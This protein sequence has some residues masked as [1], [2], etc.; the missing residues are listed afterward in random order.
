MSKKTKI[1]LK[2]E[3][4]KLMFSNVIALIVQLLKTK[5]LYLIL[6][7]GTGKTTDIYA[8][9]MMDIAYDMPGCYYA[10]VSDTY[11]NAIKNVVPSILEGWERNGY[12]EDIHYVVGKR[13]PD[14]FKKP[15]KPPQSWKHTIT[16]CTG[17]H[18]KLVSMDRPST[19]AG[20]SYQ[21]IGGDEAKYLSEQK[22]NKLTPAIRG[23][24]VRFG[25]SVYYRGRTFMTDMPNINH[26]EHDWILRMKKNMNPEQIELIL[27]T[28][29]TLNDIRKQLFIYEDLL[30]KSTTAG[31]NYKYQLQVKKIQKKLTRWE[32]RYETIRK[33]STF[34]YE[35]SSY[36]N[37]DILTEGFFKDLMD[38]MLFGEFKTSVLTISPTLEKG[39]RF[40]GNLSETNFYSDSYT[41]GN[42]DKQALTRKGIETTSLDLKYVIHN[43]PIEVGLD[44]GN[45]CSLPTAQLQPDNKYRVLK[46]FFTLSPEFLPELG[47][48]FREFYKFHKDKTVHLWHDRAANA[49]KDVGEDHASKIKKAIEETK[50]G[51]PSGWSCT[52]M[53]RGQGNITHQQEYELLSAMCLGLYGLP[54]LMIDKNECKELKSSMENTRLIIR[55]DKHG[56]KTI[57]KDKSS[58]KLPLERLPME[59]TNMSDALKYLI[60][61]P[62]NL[63]KIKGEDSDGWHGDPGTH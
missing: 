41:Y 27:Q 19:G 4:V 58:E 61:T 42:V 8:T 38:T 49:W 56:N 10:Q 24:Y 51:I 21:H 13:P 36:A 12:V 32:E 3:N 45:M 57:H 43:A 22:I 26:R 2:S 14:H 47:E 31:D 35:G 18:I 39:Q 33:E 34:Y 54:M 11:M 44:P 15:Y 37:A 63:D 53:S 9:R 60:C 52:L 23:E 62:E 6:G 46:N 59:S 1:D 25:K 29:F 30:D 48:K 17:M 5:F 20:D 40:Y 55:E 16:I 50:D 28:A 7:R